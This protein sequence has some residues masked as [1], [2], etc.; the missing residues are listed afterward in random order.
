MRAPLIPFI[1]YGAFDLYP[2]G[3]WVNQTGKVTVRYLPPIIAENATRDEMF[4]KLRRTT[5]NAIKECPE[6]VGEDISTGFWFASLFSNIFAIALQ[7][8]LLRLFYFVTV[9]KYQFPYLTI[10]LWSIG[11]TMFITLALYVY[12]V[13]LVDLGGSKKKGMWL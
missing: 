9:I 3:S 12:Y 8:Y 4:R 7:L 11:V 10:S 13:Y 6:N 5:L 1:I 2:V